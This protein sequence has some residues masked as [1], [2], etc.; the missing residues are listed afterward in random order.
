MTAIV[1]TAPNKAF[2]IEYPD[3]PPESGILQ[4]KVVYTREPET[5]REIRWALQIENSILKVKKCL[6]CDQTFKPSSK[7]NRI[8]T[9][10]SEKMNYQVYG[11]IEFL[12]I[13]QTIS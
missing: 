2:R 9:D 7:F 5:E 11:N 8:C 13:E 4:G 10:C 3:N 1:K 12:I 6:S